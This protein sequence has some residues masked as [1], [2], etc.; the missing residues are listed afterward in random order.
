MP[1]RLEAL[2]TLPREAF[3]E[4]LGWVFEGSPWVAEGAWPTRPWN[5]VNMLHAAMCA[6]V[7]R[8]PIAMKLALIRAHPDLGSRARMAEAS[9]SEQKGAGLDRLNPDEYE[10]IQQLNRAYTLKFGF[11]FILA[12]KGKTKG[13][14]F[15]ALESRLDHRKEEELETALAE[16]YKIADF[17]LWDAVEEDRTE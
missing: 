12:V 6:T 7:E 15:A 14:V 17:R 5:S 4:A 9:V 1:L 16:I 11:P 13:E 3:V 8:A 10:R 2:N